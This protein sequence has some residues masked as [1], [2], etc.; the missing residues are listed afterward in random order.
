MKKT[1]VEMGPCYCWCWKFQMGNLVKGQKEASAGDGSEL[2]KVQFRD[3]SF[4]KWPN[5]GLVVA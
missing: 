5:N 3:L 4:G 2:A 1:T